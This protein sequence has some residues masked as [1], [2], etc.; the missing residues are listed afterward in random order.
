MKL[1]W[2]IVLVGILVQSLN[3]FAQDLEQCCD[4]R[5]FR[6]LDITKTSETLRVALLM[7]ID[8]TSFEQIKQNAS[9]GGGIEIYGIPLEAKASY[10]TF[11]DKRKQ[12][13][14]S[15]GYEKFS[16]KALDY[17]KNSFD[18][19]ATEAY[20]KCLEA[21]ASSAYGLSIWVKNSDTNGATI[22]V[23]YRPTDNKDPF[24]LQSENITI[25]GGNIENGPTALAN[26]DV[27]PFIIKRIKDGRGELQPLR[28]ALQ[29]IGSLGGSIYIPLPPKPDVLPTDSLVGIW[30]GK[31]TYTNEGKRG[32]TADIRYSVTKG[33]KEGE[34]DVYLTVTNYTDE[35]KG[36]R[37]AA[38][39][40]AKRAGNTLT[41]QDSYHDAYGTEAEYLIQGK[42]LIGNVFR[43]LN[44]QRKHDV[45]VVEMTKVQ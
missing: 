23:R 21:H 26:G 39:Q 6:N 11:N 36:Q 8:E 35:R 42:K 2:T 16:E 22:N 28:F 18:T 30:E 12:Y 44:N 17:V 37:N 43:L 40:K 19:T 29:N 5:H 31:G 4:P 14:Q 38:F 10:A 24:S 33:D 3:A 25:S 9:A 7:S 20:Q 1:T 45:S 34:Y 41:V 27:T 32:T 15:L 13:L